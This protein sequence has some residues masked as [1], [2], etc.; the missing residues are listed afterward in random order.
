[1][2]LMPCPFC[3]SMVA[4]QAHGICPK[5]GGEY[6]GATEKAKRGKEKQRM[7]E[8]RARG[9]ELRAR[10]EAEYEQE[11]EKLGS[12]AYRIFGYVVILGLSGAVLKFLISLLLE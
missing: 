8:Q 9:Q 6:V 10:R 11:M 1:M 5:C 7:K 12:P 3:G 4:D 2:S